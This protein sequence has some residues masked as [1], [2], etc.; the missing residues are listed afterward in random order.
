MQRFK[1]LIPAAL[2]FACA[3]AC[4]PVHAQ[5]VGGNFNR[6]ATF[7]AFRNV[8]AGRTV[9]KKSV[10]EIVTASEDGRL[11]AYTDGE[12]QGIGLIDI[13]NPASPQA[14]GFIPVEGEA[15]SVVILR[16]KIL[17]AVDAS[18]QF[19]QPEGHLV[20][21]DIATRKVIDKCNLQGQPDSVALDKTGSHIVVVMENQR[22]EALNKGA[23]PQLPAGNVT[24]LPIK[25]GVPDCTGA[26]PIDLTGLAEIAPTD[27]EPEFVK[28]NSKGMA[29]VSLQEN[30]HLVLIDVAK[31]HVVRHFSAGSV[32]LKEVDLKRDGII[33]PSESITGVLREPDAVAWL[34]DQRFVTANE[35]DYKG[36][37][38]SF[39]IMNIDGK[40][41][42]D[43]GAMLDHE[44]IRLGHYPERR[45][46][47]KGNE[48]E[49]AEVGVFGKDRLIFIGSERSSLISVWLDQGPGKAPKYLQALPAGAGPE[50]LLAM[51]Q[52]KLLVVASETDGAARA[53]VSIY[54]R[55][56][57]PAAYPTLMSND[58]PAGPPIA[59]GAISGTSAD[60]QQ[61][62]RLWAVTDSAYSTTRILQIDANFKPAL[63]TNEITVTKGGK[64]ANFDAEG[65]AQ[66]AD[67]SFWIAS[68]GDPAKKGGA[69]KDLLL[70]V[71]A[72][73]EV[74]EEIELPAALASHAVRFGF[75]GVTRTGSGADEVV[76]IAVQREWKDDP[77]GFTKILRYHPATKAWGVLH[78]PLDKTTAEGGWVGL[79]EIS[80]VGP[81]EFVVIE[82]DNQFGDKS[83]KTLRAFSVA[84]LVPAAVSDSK[85]PVVSKRLVRDLV[86]E[87]QKPNGIVLD[88]VESF[89]VDAAGNA[90]AITDN[91]GVDGTNGETQFL[92]LGRLPN[93]R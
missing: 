39:S 49:S 30:N 48:P 66:R 57:T 91:D 59:W 72:K 92:R 45:S 31:R 89:A 34:D 11:L 19:F 69:L 55:G 82:R 80:A 17:A 35:G 56:D 32:N 51:P 40:V 16:G 5:A 44:A 75:E 18:K 61:P 54:Q 8:P 24:I 7:E 85:V 10:A 63:I 20:T 21:I 52:R 60:I 70:H 23:I 29:V 47:A 62:G 50:G 93:L 4:L 78:Y 68:E 88:K 25:N 73:G 28:V 38:R 74:Q 14:A 3:Q 76:W 87:L 64:P 53:S 26:Y 42:F 9:S 37:S 33:K 36:G 65:I 83:L 2:A 6:V 79:S 58:T 22:D 12:Q 1:T 81:N 13:S 71:T 90:F 27:P 46:S 43:S 15:T 67:G 84:G 86:P 77:Q 41:E